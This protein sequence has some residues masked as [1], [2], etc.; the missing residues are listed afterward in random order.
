[1]NTELLK[2]I[3]QQAVSLSAIEK[4]DL[5]NFLAEQLQLDKKVE[6][7]ESVQ[8]ETFNKHQKHLD[9]LKRNREKYAGKYVA[10]KGNKLV[11]VGTTIRKAYTQAR[12]K[13]AKNP[14]LVQVYSENETLFGGW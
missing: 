2:K 3:K 12:E 5:A 8:N 6:T 7:S 4:Q 11:G 10:L 14:F 9:W 1:M 13:N